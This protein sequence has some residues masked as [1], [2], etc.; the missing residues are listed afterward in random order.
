MQIICWVMTDIR[1]AHGLD[2]D[3]HDFEPS[4]IDVLSFVLFK[5]DHVV[6]FQPQ[7]V[8]YDPSIALL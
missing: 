8:L 3:T 6:H 1:N 2:T 4:H 7:N 5:F